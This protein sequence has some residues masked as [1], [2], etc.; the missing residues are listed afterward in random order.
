MI[1]RVD[2]KWNDHFENDG[3]LY[4]LQRIVEMLDYSSID[5]FR[6][7]LLNTCRLI[8]EF[9]AISNGASKPYH[10]EEVFHEFMWSFENDIILDYKLGGSKKE[11]I[12]K[13]LND[14]SRNRKTFMLFLQQSVSRQYLSWVIDYIYKAV[15]EN[16]Q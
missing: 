12:I 10:L 9:I 11:Q 3:V 2:I 15:P 16:K 4:F 7:P 8:D 1:S 14:P 6:A 5:I 13:K